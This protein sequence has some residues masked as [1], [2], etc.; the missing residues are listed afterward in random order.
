MPKALFESLILHGSKQV[1]PA[2]LYG[3]AWKK[4]RTAELVCQAV[5]SGFR[6][7]DT[8]AQPKHYR[9]NLVGEGLRS[10]LRDGV[11]LRE[12]LFVSQKGFISAKLWPQ[13]E[14]VHKSAASSRRCYVLVSSG[15]SGGGATQVEARRL[16][17]FTPVQAGCSVG[18]C[19]EAPNHWP[20]DSVLPP[21]FSITELSS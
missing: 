15:Q 18:S 8:A 2:F 14:I 5:R 6:G 13:K 11:C 10:V 16:S 19:P 3:T 21:L 12:D 17:L 1:I 9:E 20:F 7:V 4:E